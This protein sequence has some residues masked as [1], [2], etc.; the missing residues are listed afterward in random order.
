V[1]SGRL[2]L[3]ETQAHVI[4]PVE[5]EEVQAV[6]LT[7]EKAACPDVEALALRFDRPAE[8]RMHDKRDALG[9]TDLFDLFDT[10]ETQY[11]STSLTR[12]LAEA[13]A[14]KGQRP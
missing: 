3:R 14:H 8:T 12:A 7:S 9:F 1:T 4:T 11:R 5:R 2:P 6:R 13:A 10:G